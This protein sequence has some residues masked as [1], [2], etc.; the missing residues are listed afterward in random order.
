[1]KTK[2]GPGPETVRVQLPGTFSN[3]SYTSAVLLWVCAYAGTL[4]LPGLAPSMRHSV[5]RSCNSGTKANRPEIRLEERPKSFGGNLFGRMPSLPTHISDS[6]LCDYR[7]VLA[8]RSTYRKE[9]YMR[10]QSI[11]FQPLYRHFIQIVPIFCQLCRLSE[12]GV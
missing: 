10:I 2:R 11:F 5:R 1:M 3:Y 6:T 8:N 7:R 12:K 4:C 9:L